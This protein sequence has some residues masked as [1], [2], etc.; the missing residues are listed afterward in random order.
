M[1]DSQ[2]ST[3]EIMRA[4]APLPTYTTPPRQSDHLDAVP[5]GGAWRA[6]WRRYAAAWMLG[7]AVVIAPAWPSEAQARSARRPPIER[8]LSWRDFIRLRLSPWLLMQ[9]TGRPADEL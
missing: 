9:Q 7:V 5:D 4:Q 1:Y 3:G 6:R 2:K 8:S